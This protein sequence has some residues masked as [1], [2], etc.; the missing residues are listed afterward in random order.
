VVAVAVVVG[1]DAAVNIAIAHCAWLSERHRTLGRLLEQLGGDVKVFR[2]VHREHAAVWAARVWEWAC[3]VGGHVC[4]L[5]DDV[6]LHPQF[7]A[8][9][10]AMV[11]A[12]PDELISLHTSVPGAVEVARAGYAWC[13]SYWSTGPGYILPPLLAREF[14]SWGPWQ[15]VS[16]INE[17]N[18]MIH[19]LWERQRP[20]WC[21]IP[22]PL[23][24][25]ISVPSSLGYDHHPNRTPSVPWQDFPESDLTD[26]EYWTPAPETPHVPNPWMP[27]E[28]LEHIRRMLARGGQPCVM[29]LSLE[30][31]VG[32]RGG[33]LVC[34]NCVAQLSSALILG[35]AQP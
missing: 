8:I 20:A 6:I 18:R 1:R 7:R 30:G 9:C 24:H 13:R 31:V 22:A 2:S 29:C 33:P 32:P 25:D 5:N 3:E 16:R 34:Q 26:P 4:V 21:A 19:V 11:Q 10:D 15:F 17:D 14:L 23:M 12:I 28:K 27:V 35:K